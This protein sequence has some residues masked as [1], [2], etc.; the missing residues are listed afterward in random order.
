MRIADRLIADDLASLLYR[1]P[2]GLARD[3][4]AP[5]IDPFALIETRETP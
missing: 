1:S 4:Y 5:D 3:R 2:A